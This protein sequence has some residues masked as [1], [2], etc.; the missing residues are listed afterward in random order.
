MHDPCID[1]GITRENLEK[2]LARTGY[3][4][5]AERRRRNA[6]VLSPAAYAVSEAQ[7]AELT[8]LSRALYA[9][10]ERVSARLC[11]L[12]R[13]RRLTHPEAALLGLAKSGIRGLR[14]PHEHDGSIPPVIKVDLMEDR[15][16]SYRIAEADVYNPRGFGYLALLDATIPAGFERVGGGMD[17]LATLVAQFAEGDQCP[18]IVSGY[19]GYYYPTY[20]ILADEL[21]A[22][23][24]QAGVVLESELADKPIIVERLR[25]TFSI[26]DTL[27]ARPDLRD[28]LLAKSRDGSLRSFMPPAAYLGSKAFLPA[29]AECPTVARFLPKTTLIGRRDGRDFA[30]NGTGALLKNVTSSGH[31][32]IVF[33]RRDPEGFA[34]MLA[35]ARTRRHPHWIVQEEVEQRRVSVVVFDG[36]ERTAREYF[37]RLTAYITRDGLLGLEVTGREDGFVHGAPDCIQIPCVRV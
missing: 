13:S 5:D 36:H 1:L 15:D 4:L 29:Y 33:S 34:R 21:I 8:T 19:E 17:A 10:I 27:Y 23:S 16:G 14:A 31:K 28:A 12:A 24:V 25:A 20:R 32:N 26:P 6:Y 35:E 37:L 22:R 30:L 18:I 11:A 3:W 2:H 7:H 9:S